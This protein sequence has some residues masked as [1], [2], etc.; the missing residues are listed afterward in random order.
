MYIHT[1]IA[2]TVY[3][4]NNPMGTSERLGLLIQRVTILHMENYACT[5]I[6]SYIQIAFVMHTDFAG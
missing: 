5:V 1:Y 4:V 2:I 3:I 6:I